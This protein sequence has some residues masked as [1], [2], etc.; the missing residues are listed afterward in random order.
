VLGDV[1]VNP[2]VTLTIEP[3]VTLRFAANHDTLNGGDFT[4]LAE[5]R[6]RG[7]L[8]CDASSGDSIRFVSA[9]TGSGEWGQIKI[10]GTGSATF[11]TVSISGAT[12]G[13]VL[14]GPVTLEGVSLRATTMGVQAWATCSMTDVV[15][16]DAALGVQV[17][18]GSHT[19]LR[20]MLSNV[21]NGILFDDTGASGTIRECVIHGCYPV[22]HGGIGLL[23]SGGVSTAPADSTQ[24]IPTEVAGFENGVRNYVGGG[25]TVRNLVVRNTYD[26][27]L[28]DF[29]ATVSY[30]TVV[31]NSNN[32]IFAN[33]PTMLVY[34]SIVAS[35]GYR[36]IASQNNNPN[37]VADYTDS[38]SNGGAN[39][40][41]ITA[42][43][44]TA[45]FSPFFVNPAVNDYHLAA[46]S[47]F[48][49]Y[50]V[51]RGEIGAYGPGACLAVAVPSEAGPPASLKS[52]PNPTRGAAVLEFEQAAPGRVTVDILDVLGR[53][54]GR[55]ADDFRAAG[56]QRVEW[57]GK[58]EAGA[59]IRPGLYFWR[60]A[61]ASGVRTGRLVVSR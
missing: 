25:V 2:G 43:V 32:G 18:S 4:N 29:A 48:K 26:G 41:D 37:S 8:A 35:N 23:L 54:I 24:P 40:F 30:C 6:I 12:Y 47:I 13:V 7:I 60:V 16:A 27:I 59:T 53:R 31:G 39:C 1:I 22:T 17:R 36:G 51:S 57:G 11:R 55:V 3:G 38:W 44:N 49:N 33:S 46:S 10:E 28:L 56:P 58:D 20:L 42:G 52:S 14:L 19:F 45:S 34:N 21:T 15:I 9:G 5:L 61:S 50:S